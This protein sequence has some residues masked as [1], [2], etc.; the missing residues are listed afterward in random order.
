MKPGPKTRWCIPPAQDAAFVCPMEQVRDVYQRPYDPRRPVVGREAQPQQLRTAMRPPIPA[1]PGQPARVAYAYV[2]EGVCT[3]WLFVEPLA[4]GRD[5]SVTTTT[6]ARDGAHQVKRLVDDPR[7]ADAARITLVCAN[8]NTHPLASLSQAFP[9]DEALRRARNRA[10]AYTPQQGSWLNVAASELSVLTRP[11]WDRR[12]TTPGEV[13]A[14]A[15]SWKERRNG[16]QIG[17]A[18]HFTTEDARIKLKHLYPK[19]KE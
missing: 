2:R 13:A 7:Y 11:C 12:L 9:P 6:T 17:V 3:V 1:A 4:G 18:W 15:H 19:V 10:L 8:L 5:V 16:R 14:E